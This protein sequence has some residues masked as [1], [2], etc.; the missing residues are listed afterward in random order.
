MG[1][2]VEDENPRQVVD[3]GL[4][5]WKKE[6]YLPATAPGGKVKERGPSTGVIPIGDAQKRKR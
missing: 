2:R 4:I 3:D 1:E 6:D 5:R